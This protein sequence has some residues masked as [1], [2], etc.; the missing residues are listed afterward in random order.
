[1]NTNCN[2]IRD[3][4]PLYIENLSSNESN[5][6]IEEHLSECK[7]CRDIFEKE[8]NSTPTIELSLK[9]TEPLHLIKKHIKKRRLKAVAFA[10]LI[11]CAIATIIFSYLTK[12]KYFSLE[13]SGVSIF[14]NDEARTMYIDFNNNITSYKTSCEIDD[15]SNKIV[16]I[17]A[18]TTL[19]DKLLKKDT[20]AIKL[21]KIDDINAVYY[22]DYFE[23]TNMKKIYDNNYS[24]HGGI[25]ALPRLVLGYYFL[26][27]CAAMAII[28]VLWLITK[29]KNFKYIFM[30]PVSYILSHILLLN[31]FASHSS[32]RDFI[33][34]I[35]TSIFVYGILF[36]GDSL[37][38]QRK[39]D[40][41][42]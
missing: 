18:W 25:T 32:I 17:E 21:S 42:L 38:K 3:L 8:K 31:D 9:Q 19:W 36:L 4:L 26:I 24:F 11:M 41:I 23:E 12:P 13:D 15:N 27:A 14:Q 33:F 40:N 16:E 35:I 1:M 30:L 20:P 34:N 28:G 39:D 7:E 2:T 10:T 29:E 6:L 5:S 22:I 37:I